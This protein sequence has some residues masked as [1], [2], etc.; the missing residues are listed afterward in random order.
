MNLVIVINLPW[1]QSVTPLQ[2]LSSSW[3]MLWLEVEGGSGTQ[4]IQRNHTTG[5]H[6]VVGSNHEGQQQA[7][8]AHTA[9]NYASFTYSLKL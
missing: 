6:Q 1:L 8:L 2:F 9:C 7:K 5:L 3:L 4:N